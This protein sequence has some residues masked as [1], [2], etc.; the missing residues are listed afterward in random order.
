MSWTLALPVLTPLATAAAAMIAT[1]W[2]ASQRWI[3]VAGATA[4]LTA[5]SAL[6]RRVATDGI[7]VTYVGGWPPPF[8]IT[9]VADHLSALMVAVAAV[10]GLAVSVYSLGDIDP[11][12]AARGHY[13]LLHVL[14]AGV[15]G[16]FLTGDLFNLYVWFEVMLVASFVLVAHGGELPQLDGAVKYVA[17]NFFSSILFLVAAGIVYGMTGTLNLADL[18]TRIPTID[19]TGPVTAA[20]M[21]LLVA[22]GIK[23]AVFPFFLWLPTSYHTPPIAVAAVFAGLLTKVGVYALIR[24]FTLVFPPETVAVDRLLL[25]ISGLTMITGVL[26]AAAQ[27]DV[28]RI[29]AFHIISQVGY[30]ILGLALRTP[31]AILGSVFYIVHHILVKTN[32]FLIAGLVRRVGGS[33]DLRRPAGLYRSHPA[34]AAV[35]LVPALSLAGLPPLS[36]FWAKLLL[37]KAGLDVGAFAIVATALLVGLLTLFSMTKIWGAAFW[38]EPEEATTGDPT[39]AS[40]SPG[41]ALL[42]PTVALASLTLATGLWAQPL[43]HL[44]EQAAAELL[45]PARYVDAVLG[46]KR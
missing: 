29:L 26:G 36:G 15:S 21:V 33:F 25:W 2:P 43:F 20:A 9:L 17:S 31:L 10:V 24:T 38:K 27:N 42:A 18:A 11:R 34:L 7:L 13:P 5:A 44:A 4:H 40:D 23:A 35:F 39:A 8:A 19:A 22:F 45:D 3:G 37:V 1:P 30:M 41:A 14:L 46:G 28:R 32:L 6:L 12:R 16:A